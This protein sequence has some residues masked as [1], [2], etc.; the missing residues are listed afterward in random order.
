MEH[1]VAAGLTLASTILK[2]I[3]EAV[4][5]NREAQAKILR[6]E[7]VLSEDSPT[8]R[9]WREALERAK[10]KPLAVPVDPIIPRPPPLPRAFSTD[11]SDDD[12]EG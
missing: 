9:A 1:L 2:L 6:V 7:A 4:A 10:R 3:G 12:S 5:G 8:E 11:A